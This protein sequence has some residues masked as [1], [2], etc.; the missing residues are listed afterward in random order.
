[1]L[2]CMFQSPD[3]NEVTITHVMS[4]MCVTSGENVDLGVM[5]LAQCVH[6]DRR[7][8]WRFPKNPLYVSS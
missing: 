4:G 3:E 8:M 2:S 5:Y 7:Q 6:G 1:M